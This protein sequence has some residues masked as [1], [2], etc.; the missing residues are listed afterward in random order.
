MTENS[1]PTVS[2]SA[3]LRALV[4]VKRNGFATLRVCPPLKGAVTMRKKNR[5]DR[6]ELDLAVSAFHVHEELDA[7]LASV[8]QRPT[9]VSARR[10]LGELL[11]SPRLNALSHL[12]GQDQGAVA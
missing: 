11:E 8:W 5:E 9:D 7:K 6:D 12:G 1:V 2:K 10:Q 4:V 3:V